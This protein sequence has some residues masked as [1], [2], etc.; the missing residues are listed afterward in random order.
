MHRHLSGP[1]SAGSSGWAT[2]APPEESTNTKAAIKQKRM[3]TP[4]NAEVA[5]DVSVVGTTSDESP[6]AKHHPFRMG[7][8]PTGQGRWAVS[9][10]TATHDSGMH[11]EM[12]QIV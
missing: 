3:T 10:P 2:D 9:P 1:Y 4:V 8:K 11:R 12:L 7:L 5:S 6:V